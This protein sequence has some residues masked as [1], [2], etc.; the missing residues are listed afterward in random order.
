MKNLKL[1]LALLLFTQL[2]F[3]QQTYKVTEGELQFINPEKGIILKKDKD[4]LQLTIQSD[5]NNNNKMK[6]STIINKISDAD[7]INY[8][9]NIKNVY[10][11]DIIPNYDFKK[12]KKIRFV[13]VEKDEFGEYEL[14][15]FN[16]ETFV[17]YQY[18]FREDTNKMELIDCDEYSKYFYADFGENKKIIIIS[19]NFNSFIIPTKNKLHLL[20]N[21]SLENYEILKQNKL[22]NK[23]IWLTTNRIYN[24]QEFKIDTL[25]NK[26]VQLKNIYDN[27]L[28]KDIYD[29]INVN[30]I[31][32]CYRKNNVDLYNLAFTKLNKRRINA[33]HTYM[34]NIQV[35]Q[36]NELKWI[37]WNGEE[38]KKPTFFQGYYGIPESIIEVKPSELKINKSNNTHYLIDKN[39]YNYHSQIVQKDSISLINTNDINTFYFINNSSLNRIINR[40]LKTD[41]INLLSPKG[42]MYCRY[43]VVYYKKNNGL[44]GFNFIEKFINPNFKNEEFDLFQELQ[45]IEFQELQS[46]EFKEPFYKLEKNNLFMFYPLQNNFKYKSLDQFQYYFA[47]FELPNGK[48]GWLSL[49][50]KE[51]LDK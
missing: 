45:S 4:Y 48:K 24:E 1:I 39:F 10:F 37:D 15:Q 31:I 25:K 9:H 16:N 43:D 36:N 13:S 51:Y 19:D 20:G 46:I 8:S 29:S 47:R 14:T 40:N 30:N 2:N 44:L 12:I 42:L 17:I 18:E 50:G 33:A 49:D 32:Y 38:L 41:E 21:N 23:H 5:I 28:I 3:A 26:K 6:F 27:V 34:G 22:T 35:L 7:F 11:N